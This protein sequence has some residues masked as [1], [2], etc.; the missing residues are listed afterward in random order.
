MLVTSLRVRDQ[1]IPNCFFNFC[2]SALLSR[3]IVGSN[4][5]KGEMKIRNLLDVV[6]REMKKSSLSKRMHRIM[7]LGKVPGN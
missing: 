5:A 3:L 4:P 6:E 7:I 1:L 2:S